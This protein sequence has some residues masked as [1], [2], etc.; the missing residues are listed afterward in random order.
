M[1]RQSWVLMLGSA[2]NMLNFGLGALI[3]ECIKLKI[4]LDESL[5]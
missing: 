4:L 5:L 3:Y 1:I 2:Q